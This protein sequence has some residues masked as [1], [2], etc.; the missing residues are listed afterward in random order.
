MHELLVI[1]GERRERAAVAEVVQH[2]GEEGGVPVDERAAL[3]AKK[4]ERI[5]GN[6]GGGGGWWGLWGGA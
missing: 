3:G 6:W 4:E 5:E 1:L 2:V